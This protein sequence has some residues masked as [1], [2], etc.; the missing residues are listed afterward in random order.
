MSK[1]KYQIL[2]DELKSKKFFRKGVSEIR[3]DFHIPS[4]G[5]KT[6]N[7]RDIWHNWLVKSKDR[8][9]KFMSAFADLNMNCFA[10]LDKKYKSEAASAG[11]L[12]IA[13]LTYVQRGEY[14]KDFLAY[15]LEKPYGANL[16]K[17]ENT[18]AIVVHEGAEKQDVI[19]FVRKEWDSIRI[20]IGGGT[21]NKYPRIRVRTKADRDKR[22]FQL[23][24][25]KTEE[26]RKFAIGLGCKNLPRR[27]DMLVSRIMT[28]EPG[29]QYVD[30]DYIRKIVSRMRGGK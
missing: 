13:L 26:L 7:E 20:L 6:E 9:K 11:N 4:K 23:Y 17:F 16:R 27:K 19:D 22:I 12:D 5:F 14:D 8:H 21:K 24:S 30:P 10:E 29:G 18:W 25:K 2:W 28:K 1:T 3:K 15:N